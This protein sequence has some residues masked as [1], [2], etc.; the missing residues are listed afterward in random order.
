MPHSFFRIWLHLV[1]STKDRELLIHLDREEIIYN[2]IES[3]LNAMDCPVKIINGVADH[4]HI[5][6]LQNPHKTISETIKQIKGSSSHWINQNKLIKGPFAWQSGYGVFSVS[7]SQKEK[8]IMYITNQKE[9]HK[10]KTFLEEYD[11]F[12][13]H[14]AQEIVAHN[15]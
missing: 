7:E 15:P 2:F 12:L 11:E 9:H 3:Q 13:K 10:K 1:F 14:Y 8:V 6:Y 4:L 5:L